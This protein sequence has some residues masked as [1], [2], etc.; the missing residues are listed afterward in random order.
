MEEEDEVVVGPAA[1][2]KLVNTAAGMGAMVLVGSREVGVR[3]V[4]LAPT[5]ETAEPAESCSS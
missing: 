3:A 4:A 1:P 5:E 2:A